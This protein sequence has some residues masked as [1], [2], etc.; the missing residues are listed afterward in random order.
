[1][2]TINPIGNTV[3]EFWDALLQL[4]NGVNRIRSFDPGDYSVQIAAEIELPDISGYFEK[5]KKMM[6]RLDRNII[7]AYIASHQAIA[8]AGLESSAAP[9][10]YGCMIGTG[11]AGLTTHMDQIPKILN[12]GMNAA[13]PFYIINAIPNTATA[14]VSQEWALHGPSYTLSSACATSNHAIATSAIMIKAGLA[15]AFVTGGTEAVIS[16]LAIGAF[17][18][19][20]AL[21]TRNDSPETASR[22]FERDRDGFVLGEGAGILC[23]EELEHARTRGAR[24]YAELTGFGLSSDGH[25]LVAP[26]PEGRGAAEAITAALET[27]RLN[28]EDLDLINCHGTSTPIGDYIESLAI[29]KALGDYGSTVPVHSTKSM[30]GHLIGATGG[31]ELIADIP[32]LQSGLIHATANQ[33]E[34]DPKIGL[35]VVK[36]TMEG[37]K[38]R[39]VLSNGFGFGGHNASVIFSKFEA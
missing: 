23:I 29:H 38:V 20:M 37:M 27:A 18:N 21:S 13:S 16:P 11:E 33:F 34:Q 35:N 2:G 7:L 3:K 25:D 1:M 5:K 24:I 19:I 12:K 6:R 22:P 32:A 9:H 31:V 26:H 28:P 14:Y 15:D 36:E 30:T 4:K 8:D 10:R 17:G 39:H